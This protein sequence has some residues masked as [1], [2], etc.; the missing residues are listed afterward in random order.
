[1]TNFSRNIFTTFWWFSDTFLCILQHIK[2]LAHRFFVSARYHTFSL[3]AWSKMKNFDPNYKNKIFNSLCINIFA[4]MVWVKFFIFD[5]VESE[6]LP[7]FVQTKKRCAKFLILKYIKIY[8]K[9]DKKLEKSLGKS[10]SFL[11]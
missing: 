6:N 11:P 8:Q 1:M 9:I 5:H 4:F 7:Y 2:N 10:W 3:A